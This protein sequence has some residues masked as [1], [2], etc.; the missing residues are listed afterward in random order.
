[1]LHVRTKI[2]TGTHTHTHSL[3]P[4]AYTVAHVQATG[5]EVEGRLAQLPT[6]LLFI[7]AFST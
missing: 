7:T 5:V 6:I 3:T 2:Q 4:H 1:M